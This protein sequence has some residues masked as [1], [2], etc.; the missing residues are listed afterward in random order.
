MRRALLALAV[1]AWMVV[2]AGTGVAWGATGTMPTGTVATLETVSGAAFVPLVSTSIA[3]TFGNVTSAGGPQPI[4]AMRAYCDGAVLASSPGSSQGNGATYTIALPGTPQAE[5]CVLQVVLRGDGAYAGQSLTLTTAGSFTYTEGPTPT[6]TASP[7]PT[8]V[9]SEE[10]A[11]SGVQDVR[12]V[13]WDGA[14]QAELDLRFMSG[15]AFGAVMVA[16]LTAGA[17][18]LLTR[19]GS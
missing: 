15:L 6:P 9:P 16:M 19:R 10:P 12:L 7:T 17:L 4:W 5:S 1:A 18:A 2:A 11:P 13:G 8:P 14:V 3:V